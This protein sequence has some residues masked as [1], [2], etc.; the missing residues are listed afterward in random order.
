MLRLL[1]TVAIF[2]WAAT[3]A[4]GPVARADDDGTPQTWQTRRR[5]DEERRADEHTSAPPPKPRQP[6]L[7]PEWRHGL[8]E[9]TD[10]ASSFEAHHLVDVRV[11][12]GY[13]HRETRGQLKREVDSAVPA[14]DTALVFRDLVFARSRDELSLR[15]EIGLFRDLMFHA[16]L[17]I[18]LFE[19]TSLSYDRSASPCTLPPAPNATCVAPANSSTVADG[20]APGSGFDASHGGGGTTDPLLFRGARRGA[21]GG[22]GA[23]VLDTF[24][25]GLSWAPLSQRRDPAKPTWVLSIEPRLSVGT[26]RA[27][28]RAAPDANH[29]VAD[30]VH[31][32]A[33]RTAVSRRI[34]R[35]EPY[36][37]LFYLLPIARS[38]SAFVD[39][40]AAEKIKDPQQQAGALFGA[41]I[42]ALERGR[43]DWRV[44]IDVRGRLEGHFAGRG[45]S[46]AWEMFAGSPALRCDA[47]SNPACDATM[48]KNGY[49]DKPFSGVTAIDAYATLGVELAVDALLTR[50]FRLRA[51]FAYARDQSH[52]I[53]GD[54]VG[55]PLMPG[56]RV[57][58]PAEFNPA[59]RPVFDQVGRRFLVDNV[60]TFDFRLTAQARF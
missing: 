22:S 30:G 25:F 54:D 24:S 23:D 52:L 50:W 7:W 51:G 1:P 8:A 3:V 13:L 42:I 14:Q 2:S 20:I 49:Q 55:T 56:G 37:G 58:M 46:E 53:T 17:P 48:T 39:S 12:I 57:S 34:G 43:P 45:Y 29:G 5:A 19:Q 6:P 41:E 26:I 32:I 59:Y 36:F 27:F 35:F 40:G 15:A 28:D 4:I 31:R 47:M 18:V 44:A 38:D 11:S 60:D 33:F 21:A 10:L 9:Q 16:E